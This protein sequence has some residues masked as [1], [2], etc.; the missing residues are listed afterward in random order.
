MRGFAAIH[1]VAHL[2]LGILHDD[3]SLGGLDEDDHRDHEHD[4]HNQGDDEQRRQGAR[5]AQFEGLHQRVRQGR[6]DAGK[7]DQRDAVA[8]AAGRDLLAQPHQEQGAAD[9]R[10]DGDEAEKDARIDHHRSG[11]RYLA[12]EP[13]GNAIGLEGRQDHRAVAGVLVDLLPAGL[14]FLLQRL[15]R[16]H[17]RRQDLHDDG[18]RDIRH[19]A[20][21]QHRHAADR[22]AGE[23]V[24]Q[25]RDAT[26][27]LLEDLG[28]GGRIDAGDR[29]VGTDAEDDERG[30]GEPQPLLQLGRP[31]DRTP[32]QVG[33][34]LLGGGC[35]GTSRVNDTRGKRRPR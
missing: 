26:G 16:R 10:Y 30:H 31:T 5:P 22:A 23:H 6:D 35:H 13:H 14:A 9:Q 2:A 24:Q 28:Q 8:N 7:N 34:K 32:V 11:G 15:E 33:S 3:P 25:S 4:A 1:A 20:E 12:F 19:D 29:N 17:H 21:R 27:I 18:R